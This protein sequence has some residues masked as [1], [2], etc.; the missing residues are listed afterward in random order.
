MGDNPH[1]TVVGYFVVESRTKKIVGGIWEGS[2][3]TCGRADFIRYSN[4]VPGK[5]KR[6]GFIENPLGGRLINQQTLPFLELI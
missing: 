3:F 6:E 4:R 2:G 5:S 1:L